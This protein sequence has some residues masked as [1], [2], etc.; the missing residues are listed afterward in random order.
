MNVIERA[1]ASTKIV[2]AAAKKE[3]V[4]CRER[5]LSCW[6]TEKKLYL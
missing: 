4:L 2:V 6:I 1:A 5:T 3:R